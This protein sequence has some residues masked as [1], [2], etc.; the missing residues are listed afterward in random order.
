MEQVRTTNGSAVAALVLG[1]LGLIM[2]PLIGPILALV[3]GYKARREIEDSAGA[4]EGAGMA[5]AG[6]VLGWVGIAF[7]LLMILAAVLLFAVY[8]VGVRETQHHE[9]RRQFEVMVG[10]LPVASAFR[11]ALCRRP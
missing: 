9:I 5:I 8:S 2:I 11:G 4:Q 10:F 6:I 3:F 1:I 7:A